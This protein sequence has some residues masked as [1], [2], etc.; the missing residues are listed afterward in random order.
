MKWYFWAHSPLVIVV[1]IWERGA[2]CWP[3]FCWRQRVS[4]PCITF[5]KVS[6]QST[7]DMNSIISY[8]ILNASLGNNC[9][10]I[11]G[12]SENFEESSL[13]P[14]APM[15]VK[16]LYNVVIYQSLFFSIFWPGWLIAG[17]SFYSDSKSG[18]PNCVCFPLSPQH[19]TPNTNATHSL[20]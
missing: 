15:W 9:C 1:R 11:G 16:L 10:R 17:I 20:T 14:E 6:S 5:S 13:S 4:T 2:W 3:S 19:N 8:L 12:E 18:Y 7:L